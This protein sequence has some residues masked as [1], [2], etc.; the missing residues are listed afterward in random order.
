MSCVLD[1]GARATALVLFDNEGPLSVRSL[2][3]GGRDLTESLA[4]ELDISYEKAEDVKRE[5]GLTEGAGTKIKHG[6][7]PVLE[8]LVQEIE[9][10][11]LSLQTAFDRI[12][13]TGGT[14]KLP[15]IQAFFQERLGCETFLFNAFE[16]T[17][18]QLTGHQLDSGPEFTA[19][20]GLALSAFCSETASL[21]FL[22]DEF[23]P[24]KPLRLIQGK[25]IVAGILVAAILAV[26]A[27]GFLLD[28][29]YKERRYEKIR[30]EI[31][32][33]YTATF[34]G[35]KNIV[36]EEHQMMNA[37][38]EAK[39][40]L[41]SLSVSGQAETM[42][43]LL[44]LISRQIPPQ[45]QIKV[46]ELSMGEREILIAGEAQSFEAVNQLRDRL[47]SEQALVNVTVEGCKRK[48]V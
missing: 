35:V 23:A 42:L 38:E 41:A 16:H 6:L 13:I 34:P 18:H 4:S 5:Q 10:T 14:S 17:S 28:L 1:I 15:G 30:K 8:R 24:Q 2:D 39:L 9:I 22:R 48:S 45:S 26:S 31:R 7:T 29:R 32:E 37:I 36:N 20:Y 21:E 43:D 27:V 3:I 47:D 44:N 11:R 19:A 33:V 40:G 46:T 12:Y 25:L